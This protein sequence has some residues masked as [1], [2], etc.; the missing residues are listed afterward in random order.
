M[1]GNKSSNSFKVL[2]ITVSTTFKVASKS[3]SEAMKTVASKKDD[4][5]H[6]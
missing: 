1:R 2:P 3:A 6:S 4:E 5:G